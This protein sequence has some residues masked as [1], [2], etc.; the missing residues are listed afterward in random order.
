MTPALRELLLELGEQLILQDGLERVGVV[1]VHGAV[2]GIDVDRGEL[3][4]A[5]VAQQRGERERVAA[6]LAAIDADGDAAERGSAVGIGRSATHGALTANVA[7]N[8]SV[9]LG[10]RAARAGRGPGT[11]RRG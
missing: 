7:S 6:A 9:R 3:R 11:R 1:E 8:V 2:E 5:D 10:V 4:A